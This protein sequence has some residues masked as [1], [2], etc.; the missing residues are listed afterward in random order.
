MADDPGPTRVLFLTLHPPAQAS[1]RQRVHKY[2]HLLPQYGVKP[3]VRCAMP[4]YLYD[5]WYGKPS[6]LGKALY[7]VVE[8]LLRL[9][10]LLDASRFDVVVVQKRISSI[11][12][13]GLQRVTRLCCRKLVID[14]DDAVYMAPAQ[15]YGNPVLRKL[16]QDPRQFEKALS[17]ADGAV[18]GN[19]NL[20]EYARRLCPRAD[21]VAT[22]MDME[23]YRARPWREDET[24]TIG[25][26]GSSST[27]AY[28]NTVA[29]VLAE[30]GRRYPQARFLH[31]SDSDRG[32]DWDGLAPMPAEHVTWRLESLI[33]DLHRIDIGIM[34]LA[35]TEWNR[36]K[37]GGK[38]VQ[39]MS[40][41]IPSVNSPVG[42]NSEIIEEGVNGC[43]AAGR[44]EWVD[45][46]GRLIEDAGLRRRMGENARTTAEERFSNQ[47]NAPR[48]AAVL[49][50]VAR[51]RNSRAASV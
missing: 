20:A 27:N 12:L 36:G 8:T 34:P 33:D 26:S 10:H 9:A 49:R 30:L 6:K 18:A 1:T 51:G 29:D 47:A 44:D 35:D 43:L 32:V 3:R 48:L 38:I 23:L 22:S 25:W 11:N 21:V 31:I 42:I 2:L 28:V 5:K 17:R 14:F 46:L 4:A 24:V 19:A 39:Y 37:C 16:L 40:I 7:P 45:K 15:E 41:G 50:E 13:R